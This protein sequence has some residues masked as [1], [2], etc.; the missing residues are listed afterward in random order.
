MFKP[1][2]GPMTQSP[3]FDGEDALFHAAVAGARTYGEYGLGASTLWMDQH[4]DARIIGVDTALDWVTQT[5]AQLT[6]EGHD[7]VHIDVGPVAKWGRP[8]TYR[9][10]RNFIHY[11]ESIWRGDALP[12]VVLVDGRFRVACFLTTLLHAQ[13]GT[14]I[15]FDDYVGRRTYHLVEEFAPA[16]AKNTRQAVFTVPAVQD[17]TVIKRLRDQFLM[18]ID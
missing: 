6:R 2:A 9:K 15:I 18:V 17:M 1:H 13:P 16:E 11:V 12:D 14:R 3:L 7:I 8:R 5:Q 10:R 4:T